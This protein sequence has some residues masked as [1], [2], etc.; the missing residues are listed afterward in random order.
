MHSAET[1]LLHLTNEYHLATNNGNATILML[2]DLDAAFDTVDQ[3]L[4]L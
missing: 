1:L 3:Y 2:I 4:L